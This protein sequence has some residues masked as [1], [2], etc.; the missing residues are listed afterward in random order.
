LLYATLLGQGLIWTAG[1]CLG[2]C[3]P[4]IV[5]L[6]FGAA[7]DGSVKV[8]STVA[9]LMAYQ[10]GRGLSLGL[11]GAALG[12]LGAAAGGLVRQSLPVVT[13]V[14]AAFC[15]GLALVE[16]G[17]LRLPVL[18]LPAPLARLSRDATGSLQRRGWPAALLLG[19]GLAFLPCAVTVWALALAAASAHP[20]HGAVLMALLV[21]LTT[22][23]LLIAA[24]IPAGLSRW[25]LLRGRWLVPLGLGLS[26]LVLAVMA[27]RDLLAPAGAACHG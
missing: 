16:A 17:W 20:L 25:R 24:L 6:R 13:L 14:A 1:H 7:P 5:S 8:A 22:P 3:G 9:Q 4:L 23:F 21:A 2:M 11:L 19:V 18:P 12:W 15:L 27:V 10:L 26:A